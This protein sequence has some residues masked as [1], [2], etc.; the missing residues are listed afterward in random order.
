M[1][2]RFSLLVQMVITGFV[3]ANI[4]ELVYLRMCGETWVKD[5]LSRRSPTNRMGLLSFCGPRPV[6]T[7]THPGGMATYVGLALSALY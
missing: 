5:K 7:V 3:K 6:V 1:G 4:L 2:S